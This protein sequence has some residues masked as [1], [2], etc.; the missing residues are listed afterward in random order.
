MGQAKQVH[1]DTRRAA[2]AT[3]SS[4]PQQGDIIIDALSGI[5]LAYIPAGCFMQES[6]EYGS[7]REYDG[8]E[9]PIHEVCLNAFWMGKFQVT[10]E[11]WKQIMGQ[12]PAKFQK[13]NDYPVELVSWHDV[14]NFSK[15]LNIKSGKNYRLPTEAEWEYA[16]R[17]NGSSKYSG[18]DDLDDVGWYD[19]NSGDSTH[20]VGKKKANAFS[21]YD[22][23]GNVWEWC[24]DWYGTDY[25]VSSPK[26]NPVGPDSGI[27]RVLR[28]GSYFDDS[29]YCRSVYRGR[30][31]PE[32]RDDFIG[33][34]LV[35][36][37]QSAGG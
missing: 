5:E 20:S 15:R 35:L 22:M 11:Q 16:C 31:R 23:S 26:N 2:K 9:R 8:S 37:F 24:N 7:E 32:G 4:A 12:N 29:L 33:F 19:K 13:G 3:V 34:R 28:G 6:D 30:H 18:D 17:A 1:I 25:Y 36:P 14:Q 21:L 27:R 10:Q